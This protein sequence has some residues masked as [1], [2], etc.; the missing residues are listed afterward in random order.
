MLLSSCVVRVFDTEQP[1][2]VST[3]TN[4]DSLIRNIDA[5]YF[6]VNTIYELSGSVI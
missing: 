4:K 1:S 5:I 2:D 3:V 6:C